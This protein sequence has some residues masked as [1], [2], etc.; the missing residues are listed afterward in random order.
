MND[1]ETLS[2]RIRWLCGTTEVA[3]YH[4]LGALY[5][6]TGS[7]RRKHQI[8]QTLAWQLNLRRNWATLQKAFQ[9]A[10]IQVVLLKGLRWSDSLFPFPWL[11]PTGDLDVLVC[12]E[13][14]QRASNLLKEI[15]AKPDDSRIDG[16]GAAQEHFHFCF[17]YED[18]G[19]PVLVEL[20]WQISDPRDIQLPDDI[21]WANVEERQDDYVVNYE[22]DLLLAC[23]HAYR[24][25]FSPYRT[26]VDVERMIA[27]RSEQIQWGR[28]WEL[29]NQAQAKRLV[30][31]VLY[32]S[33]RH[34]VFTLPMGAQP[35]GRFQR[36]WLSGVVLLFPPKILLKHARFYPVFML[37]TVLVTGTW[38]GAE[39]LFRNFLI[40]DPETLVHLYGVDH[41]NHRQ[42]CLAYLRHP[43]SI[44]RKH[45]FSS[46]K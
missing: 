32:L 37:F 44:L 35:F 11:R 30:A 26:I 6:L 7:D 46:H 31:F 17:R 13:D 45:L 39:R 4:L 36:I 27:L 22:I 43:F 25:G 40:P 5:D 19:P 24:H 38:P 21:L 10:G 42:L 8:M 23:I 34:L 28:F 2:C 14:V 1:I 29:A 18:S 41:T 12:A 20:H 16:G 3:D 33:A 9:E 15:G